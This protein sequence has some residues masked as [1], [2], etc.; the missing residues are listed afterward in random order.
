[1]DIPERQRKSSPTPKRLEKRPQT[2][3]SQRHEDKVAKRSKGFKT[4]GSGSAGIKS[5]VIVD[6]WSARRELKTMKIVGRKSFSITLGWLK[7]I[8]T[9]AFLHEQI[10]IVDLQLRGIEHPTP[11]EWSLIPT[12]ELESLFEDRS[13][14]HEHEGCTK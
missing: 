11:D 2:W 4:P 8:T 10:P 6:R 3:D 9:E 7:K 12:E 13:K 14:L 5:D 1:V